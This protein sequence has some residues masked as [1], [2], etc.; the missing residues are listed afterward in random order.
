[1]YYGSTPNQFFVN[2]TV[3]KT[4]L[5][6][7]CNKWGRHCCRFIMTN[8]GVLKLMTN[9]K[10]KCG[11]QHIPKTKTDNMTRLRTDYVA[12][13]KTSTICY[14]GPS[15]VTLYSYTIS[16][17]HNF[18]TWSKTWR[19]GTVRRSRG[20]GAR[21]QGRGAR[22]RSRGRGVWWRGTRGRDT[23][24]N[25]VNNVSDTIQILKMKS[26]WESGLWDSGI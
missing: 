25:G 3:E 6:D 22:G 21:A 24:L 12:I 17:V 14:C 5:L 20:H 11:F 10:W 26:L 15:T 19:H 18:K 9:V 7:A 13:G 16:S 23:Q 4:T 8:G 2:C 1:M